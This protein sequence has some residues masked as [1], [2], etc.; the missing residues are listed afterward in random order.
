VSRLRARCPDCRTLTAVSLGAEYQ[1]HSCGREFRAATVRVEGTPPLELP[2]PE[3]AVVAPED[4]DL[5][6]VL[7]ERPI[8]VGGDA[9]FHERVGLVVA[10]YLLVAD[11]RALAAPPP[12]GPPGGVG[13]PDAVAARENVAAIGRFLTA[14]GL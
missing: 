14:L 1:C 2:Y 11:A 7:P 9:D 8:V 3:A 13:F 10:G 12:G 4:P 5:E 6:G